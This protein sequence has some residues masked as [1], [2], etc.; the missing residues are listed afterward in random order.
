ML[1]VT[2]VVL[3][4]D[5]VGTIA[6]FELKVQDGAADSGVP[7]VSVQAVAALIPLIEPLWSPEPVVSVP[8][9]QDETTGRVA[10]GRSFIVPAI[11]AA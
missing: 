2:A 4:L 9:P 1:V 8:L 10:L 5:M 11:C 6:A 3:M 7:K